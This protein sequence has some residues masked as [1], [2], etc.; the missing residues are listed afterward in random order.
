[1]KITLFVL[2]VLLAGCAHTDKLNVPPDCDIV[3]SGPHTVTL[4]CH[5]NLD[6]R[7]RTK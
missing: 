1:M 5:H 2:G 7:Q 3:A 6:V 4:V